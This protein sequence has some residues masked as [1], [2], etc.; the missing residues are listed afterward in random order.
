VWSY[1]RVRQCQDSGL[2]GGA[3]GRN[4]GGCPRSS[5]TET[6]GQRVGPIVP[7]R[8]REGVSACGR[9]KLVSVEITA[10]TSICV[11]RIA[12][13][14]RPFEGGGAS[15]GVTVDGSD[16]ASVFLANAIGEASL[17]RR[18]C[19]TIPSSMASVSVCSCILRERKTKVSDRMAIAQIPP[20]EK[21]ITYRSLPLLW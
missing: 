18:S 2:I 3:A 16:R 6:R 5:G 14:A 13:S 11:S 7:A 9:L 8:Q 12:V 17:R 21:S 20:F 10:H 19:F 4:D 1:D 15:I